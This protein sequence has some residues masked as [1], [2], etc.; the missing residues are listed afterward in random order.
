M[1]CLTHRQTKRKTTVRPC[2]N[3]AIYYLVAGARGHRIVWGTPAQV[4]DALEE[5][6]R[7]GAA[8]GFNIMPPFFPTQFERFVADV[9]PILRRR[10]LVRGGYEG[11][12]LR[13]N[14]G[15]PRPPNS[16]FPR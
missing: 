5:W 7:G 8:D 13:E 2:G 11:A 6:F 15:L 4:A 12:T 16:F 10:G 1:R 14:L 3:L 9:V